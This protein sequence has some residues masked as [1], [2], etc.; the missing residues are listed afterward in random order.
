MAADDP[1]LR[2]EVLCPQAH[3]LRALLQH[4]LRQLLPSHHA[5]PAGVHFERPHRRDDD[6]S[7]RGHPGDP[8]LDVEEPLGAHVRGEP[9]LRDQIVSGPPADQVGHH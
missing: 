5:V 8:A 4:G 6:G 9:G 1:Q 7:V 3:I 2:A